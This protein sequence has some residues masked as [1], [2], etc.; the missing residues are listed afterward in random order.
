MSAFVPHASGHTRP[1]PLLSYDVLSNP[2]GF[3]FPFSGKSSELG[4]ASCV[5]SVGLDL[6]DLSL[7]IGGYS[8][9]A[10]IVTL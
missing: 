10:F 6:F 9:V 3:V 5:H 4:L 1:P 8:A 7:Y 2:P